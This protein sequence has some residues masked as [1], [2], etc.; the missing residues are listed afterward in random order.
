MNPAIYLIPIFLVL[1]FVLYEQRRQKEVIIKKLINKKQLGDD[2]QMLEL[3]KRF[4]GKECLVYTFNSQITGVMKEV[5][6]TAILLESKGTIEA[7]NLDFV[8]RIRE[9]PKNKNGKKKQVVLD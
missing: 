2:R 8:V 5:D 3:A 1:F 9:Y 4:I 7:V 6:G